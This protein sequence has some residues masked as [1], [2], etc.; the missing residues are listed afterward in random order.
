MLEQSN[1]ICIGEFSGLIN[2]I[3]NNLRMHFLL[4]QVIFELTQ[5]NLAAILKTMISL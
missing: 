5:L 3:N 1:Y 2:L 4:V